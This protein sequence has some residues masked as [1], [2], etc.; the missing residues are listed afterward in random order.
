MTENVNNPTLKP[1]TPVLS[2]KAYDLVKSLVQVII[3][4]LATFY[5]TL[6]NIWGLP[7]TESVAATLMAL[8]AFLGVFLFR[9][10]KTY[11]KSDAKFDGAI[12]IVTNDLGGA[13]FDLVVNNDP[14]SLVNLPDGTAVTFKLSKSQETLPQDT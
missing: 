10:A 14:M 11:A 7:R 3:P 2:N 9:T 8:A 4:A 6:G 5:L 1:K 12:N 13:N